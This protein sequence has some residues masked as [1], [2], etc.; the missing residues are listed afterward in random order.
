MVNFYEIGNSVASALFEY[1]TSKIVHIKNK[2]VG[3]VNRFI[4]L[5]I[6]GYVIGYVGIWYIVNIYSLAYNDFE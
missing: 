5:L 2:K 3:F 4:Q 6:I 1:D